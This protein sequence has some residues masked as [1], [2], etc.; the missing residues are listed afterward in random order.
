[1]LRTWVYIV[2]LVGACSDTAVS[3][4][5]DGQAEGAEEC[6]CDA[7]GHCDFRGADCASMG[8][9]I[10]SL[11]CGPAGPP[12]TQCRVN[13]SACTGPTCGNGKADPGEACDKSIPGFVSPSC[14]VATIGMPEPRNVDGIATC[15]DACELVTSS[16]YRC[17][18]NTKNAAEACDTNDLGGT[19]C[20][21]I[22]PSFNHGN[23]S[24]N[25]SC[26]QIVQTGCSVCGD[27]AIN[28]T[29]ACDGTALGGAS[30]ATIN[31]AFNH[32]SL[33]C[34]SC[35]FDQSG[36]SRCG[37]NV[38]DGTEA[39]DGS[40]LGSAT[41][42]AVGKNHGAPTCVDCVPTYAGCSQCGNNVKDG[43]EV[44][45]GTALA[46]QTCVGQGRQGGSL[47]CAG[48]CDA[49]DV[50]QCG[51]TCIPATSVEPTCDDVDNDCDGIRDEGC[52]APPA[53][54]ARFP[55]N[56]YTTGS[57][58]A[59]ASLRPTVRWDASPGATHYFVKLTSSCSSGS[60]ASCDTSG[61]VPL[62]VNAPAT[63]YVPASPL[64][65]SMSIPMGRRYFWQVAACNGAACSAYT[66]LR[67]LDVGR[68]PDDLNGDGY[69]DL[70]VGAVYNGA[71]SSG[72]AYVY[73]GS[74]T[75]VAPPAV[76]ELSY[77]GGTVNANFGSGV[78]YGDLDGDGFADVA[79][80]AKA[81]LADKRG[82]VCIY[83]GSA[84]GLGPASCNW[85]SP[86]PGTSF[87]FG[88]NVAIGDPDGDG[89][90][91]LAV[92]ESN[93]T[94]RIWLFHGTAS[95]VETASWGA[96]IQKPGSGGGNFAY[97]MAMTDDFDGDGF[98]D[99]IGGAP[100][101][102]VTDAGYVFR[103]SASGVVRSSGAPA[104]PTPSGCLSFGISID[105]G[106]INGDGF[107]DAA[108]GCGEP[109][110]NIGAVN[111]YLGGRSGL[112]VTPSRTL[113]NPDTLSGT[114]FSRVSLGDVDAD[115]D[116]DLVVG[117]SFNE[118]GTG[119]TNEGVAYLFR[120]NQISSTFDAPASI[121]SPGTAIHPYFAGL[122][123][124]THDFDGDG[125]PDLVAATLEPYYPPTTKGWIS[126][127]LTT[128]TGT[129]GTPLVIENPLNQ[130]GGLFG[131][132]LRH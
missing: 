99:L 115:G 64:A 96:A 85:F 4:C 58:R 70:V 106:D 51:P 90:R 109:T 27:G 45:D 121:A 19:T 48:S 56:G 71:D 100:A 36:C 130:N 12:S 33:S 29:E 42:A 110:Q 92:S 73:H 65:V 3:L 44:C 104:L 52:V 53:V 82:S 119:D 34:S 131:V 13:T 122:V 60:F 1:M 76:V 8:L 108:I 75:G 124:L 54:V 41:C 25:S 72:R 16:C 66:P 94:G 105:V 78:A 102:S 98:P 87:Y 97:G 129:V 77:P 9:P 79:V 123:D 10:G 59:A 47:G 15:S 127:F 14:A 86:M 116:D 91:D 89:Y 118:P 107:A 88:Q 84:T 57:A 68:L 23:P 20:A 17:G 21:T 32:G 114:G 117:A 101:G 69:A 39:C 40:Q 74:S 95:G 83:R 62:R 61:V 55:W 112:P 113:M 50:S 31:A 38:I 24:C 63:S 5:G 11:Q 128:T 125:R 37:N 93:G 35:S 46:G 126:V 26:T 7:S 103:G 120:W 2:A 30:C 67:Y 43:T 81:Q 28:G 49:F 18:D 132:Y 111:L 6:D 80:G 22:D